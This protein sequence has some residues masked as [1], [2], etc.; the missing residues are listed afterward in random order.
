MFAAVSAI[1]F[2]QTAANFLALPQ[3]HQQQQEQLENRETAYY[4]LAVVVLHVAKKLEKTVIKL[5]QKKFQRENKKK[6]A[7]DQTILF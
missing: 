2:P 6:V 5:C 7:A 4:S 1:N 3:N